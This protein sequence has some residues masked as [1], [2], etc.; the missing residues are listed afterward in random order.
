MRNKLRFYFIYCTI[1]ILTVFFFSTAVVAKENRQE[2]NIIGQSAILINAKSGQILWQ[3]NESLKMAPAS[4]TKMMTGIL[5]LEKGNLQDEVIT[6]KRAVFAEGSRVYLEEGETKTLE[7]LLYALL[8]N[9]ANDVAIVIA[10]K[11]GGTVEDFVQLMNDKANEIGALNTHF[12]NPNGLPDNAHYSTA[13]DLAMIAKY[14][15]HNEKFREIVATKTRDWQGD[16]WY[17]P[18]INHN[19]L[20]WRYQGLTGIKTGYTVAAGQCLVASAQRNNNELIAVVLNSKGKN[21]YSDI[22]Q[23]LDYGFDNFESANLVGKNEKIDSVKIDGK[24]VP[25][26][27]GEELTYSKVEG[28]NNFEKKVTLKKEIKLPIKKGDVLGNLQITFSEQKPI[29]VP[30]LAGVSVPKQGKV[31]IKKGNSI[32]I[33]ITVIVILFILRLRAIIKRR[34][35]RQK[36]RLRRLKE[37]KD[38]R[39]V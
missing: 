28:Q 34:Q 33:V 3:K 25:L 2:P 30:L 10:E 22:S 23:L 27:S 5:A 1:A 15:M 8:L 20:L 9:S 24:L 35:L 12:N 14:A 18:L 6:S 13:Y 32:G 37:L 17:G 36:R 21:I 29:E 11:I 4:T 7:D 16:K 38:N 39:I 26:L 31:S 19:K